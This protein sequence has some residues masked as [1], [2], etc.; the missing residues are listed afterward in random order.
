MKQ[1]EK[2]EKFRGRAVPL[3]GN[4]IDTDRIIP[5]RYMRCI[6]FAGLGRYAL[7]DERYGAD[8][9]E[10]DHVF[11]KIEFRNNPVLLVNSNFGCGSSREHA[12]WALYDYGIRLIIGESFAEIFASNC[13][14]LGITAVSLPHDRV[15]QLMETVLDNPGLEISVDL[16]TRQLEFGGQMMNFS[17]PETYR[18]A[19]LEGKWDSTAILI[20][21]EKEIRAVADTLPYLHW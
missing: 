16:K 5:A 17:I 8:G 2:L 10:K 14:S 21:N 19:L 13:N 12:P 15:L 3:P 7:Y 18:R 11:N 1:G 6:T 20:Q 9:S 4:D